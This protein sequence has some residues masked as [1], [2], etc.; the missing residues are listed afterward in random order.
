MDTMVGGWSWLGCSDWRERVMRLRSPQYA[1]YLERY[2]GGD[3]GARVAARNS[4]R[5]VL[6][7]AAARGMRADE[8]IARDCPELADW[9][10]IV[11]IGKR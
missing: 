3:D 9:L 1:R 4:L 8:M 7:M 5:E 2:F 11:F 10:G 6:G